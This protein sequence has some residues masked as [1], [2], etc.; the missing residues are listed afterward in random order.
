M[1]A[2]LN[3]CP[4]LHTLLSICISKN[5]VA[6]EVTVNL[7]V[8]VTHR[9][10]QSHKIMCNPQAYLFTTHKLSPL[11]IDVQQ[12]APVYMYVCMYVL[13]R[14]QRESFDFDFS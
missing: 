14:E 9:L 8:T 11:A 12:I 5:A 13:G 10:L 6:F 4:E 1:L 7:A 3:A 2:C